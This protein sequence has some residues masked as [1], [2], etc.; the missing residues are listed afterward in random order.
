[1]KPNAIILLIAAVLLIAPASAYYPDVVIPSSSGFL[2]AFNASFPGERNAGQWYEFRID[3]VS[4]LADVKY[5]FTVYDA[6]IRD[7]YEYRSDAWGQWWTETPAPGKKFLFVWICGYSEG[8]TW[9]GWGA[10][11]FALWID[12]VS[13]A[14]EP[15]IVS[16]IGKVNRGDSWS[17]KV[18]PRTIRFME[19]RSS[20]QDFTYSQDAYGYREGIEQG[21]MEPGKS[22]AMNGYLIFQ[23]PR[24][25]NL[26]DIQVAGWFGYFGTATWNLKPVPFTQD[27]P[28]YLTI[29][30]REKI[31]EEIVHGQRLRDGIDWRKKA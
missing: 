25:S 22:N 4:G 17:A 20:Y 9:W 26:K 21:R 23:V 1:M 3:N 13:I 27:S 15:V 6:Q 12:G 10:D 7:S 14:S 16:D 31:A 30:E 11:R 8:T 24:N 29:K 28:E 18:P 19:N 2:P 5:H